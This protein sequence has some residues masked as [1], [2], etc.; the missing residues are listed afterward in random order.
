MSQNLIA[1]IAPQ[2]GVT[3]QGQWVAVWKGGEEEGWKRDQSQQTE[4]YSEV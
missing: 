1:A 4:S 2:E 3:G